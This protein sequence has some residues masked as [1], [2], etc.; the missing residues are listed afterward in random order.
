MKFFIKIITA[1]CVSLLLIIKVCNAQQQL[2]FTIN[3][4]AVPPVSAYI[5]QALTTNGPGIH[6]T[7]TSTYNESLRDIKIYGSLKRLSPSMFSI[8]VK[9]TYIPAGI[10]FFAHETKFLNNVM[11]QNA[12]GNFNE[13]D[14]A[15]TDIN[16]QDLKEGINYKLPEG[17]YQICFTAKDAN[18]TVISNEGCAFFYICNV[19]APQFTQPVNNL[20]A[21]PTITIIQPISP[22]IFSWLPPQ[23]SCGVPAS[24]INYNF[25]LRE[26]LNGQTITDAL[27]NPYVFRKTGLTT[28]IFSLDTNLYQHILQFGKKYIMQVQA[29]AIG[30]PAPVIENNGYSRVEAF[31]Y[32]D[33]TPIANQYNIPPP[34]E[35][36]VSY[37]ERK[38]GFWYDKLTAYR[39]HS[40]NDTLVPVKEYIALALTDTGI[41]YNLSAIEL[42]LSLNPE[43]ANQKTVKLSNVPRQPFFPE[44][45][46]VKKEKFD[47]DYQ[48]SLDPDS[49]EI[50]KF[51]QHLN[52]LASL[53]SKLPDSVAVTISSMNNYLNN[54]KTSLNDV[55]G[56]TL[57]FVNEVLAEIIFTIRNYSQTSNENKSNKLKMLVASVKE[58]TETS[59]SG[60]SFLKK[61]SDNLWAG[62]QSQKNL[63]RFTSNISFQNDEMYKQYN[64]ESRFSSSVEQV[65]PFDII[66]WRSAKQTPYKPVTDAPDLNGSF[67]ISYTLASLYN[68]R[69]PEI[70]SH[71]SNE[72]ASTI[73]VAL[74]ANSVYEFWTRNMLTNKLTA[75]EKVDMKSIF[76]RNK[77]I[78]ITTKKA[79]IVLK[80]E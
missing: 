35:F 39:N 23:S 41:A 38:T 66:V 27:N 52:E 53:N 10:D 15:F 48:Q 19:A 56:I 20:I 54:F 44:V 45:P 42:F 55:S 12:F 69:N 22:V 78:G 30:N 73:Q 46:S 63:F 24:I 61:H 76:N 26:I 68:H 43:L 1:L 70:G 49:A 2:F 71:S 77:Q 13:E 17:Y 7:I 47:R 3:T 60:T 37:D 59:S 32:G 28:T 80:V 33:G 58:L 65:L 50:Q 21:S 72:L 75:A 36:Y 57:S 34:E 6:V 5:N 18:N 64:I 11:L 16:P 25:E 29:K 9:N 40:G 51:N 62:T 4:V 74:P 67:R 31:Q 8:G 79:T 14:A